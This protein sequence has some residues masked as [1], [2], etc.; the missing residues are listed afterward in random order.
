MSNRRIADSDAKIFTV[1]LECAAGEL[2]PIVG[3]DPIWD[4]KLVEDGL[5]K[6]D[7]GLLV[8]LD[9]RGCFRPLGELVDGDVYI[10][11]SSDSPGD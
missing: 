5:D 11:E 2:G 3:D 6:L 8:H 1:S 10:L 7:C 4:P 9:H